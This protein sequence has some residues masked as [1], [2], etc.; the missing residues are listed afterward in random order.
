MKSNYDV[1]EA[2]A[3]LS[4]AAKVARFLVHEPGLADDVASAIVTK[5]LEGGLHEPIP[6][7]TLKHIG[8]DELRRWRRRG[9]S[10]LEDAPEPAARE[11]NEVEEVE[12]RV[13]EVMADV[14]LSGVEGRVV[15]YVMYQG[16]TVAGAAEKMGVSRDCAYVAYQCA[17]AKLRRAGDAESK[18]E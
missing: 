11:G 18:D 15:Y 13:R 16:E 12:Q 14:E 1:A 6:F 8:I 2:V 3:L 4:R 17:L 7:V 9:A 10:S 5:V